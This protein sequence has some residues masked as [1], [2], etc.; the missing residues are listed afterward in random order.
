[1]PPCARG[2]VF[3]VRRPILN[4][5]P[6]AR[7]TLGVATAAVLAA[8]PFRTRLRSIVILDFLPRRLPCTASWFDWQG[9]MMKACG[10]FRNRPSAPLPTSREKAA[11]QGSQKRVGREAM[12]HSSQGAWEVLHMKLF[13]YWRS[14]ATL[15]VRI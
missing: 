11:T 3:T 14:L 15:R 13:G 6:C 4:G 7:R 8:I 5:A 9:R 1:M 12:T 10:A 2:P